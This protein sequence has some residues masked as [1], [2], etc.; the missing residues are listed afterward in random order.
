MKNISYLIVA[1]MIFFAVLTSC[2]E[3]DDNPKEFTISFETGEGG[4][5]VEPQTVREGE[6]INKPTPDP[7]RSGYTFMAW[8]KEAGVSNEWNFDT[9][10][11]TADMTLHAKWNVDN[12]NDGD[13]LCEVCGEEDCV[14]DDGAVELLEAIYYDG[15]V[16]VKYEY[17]EQNRIT[18]ITYYSYSDESVHTRTRTFIYNNTGY[19][20]SILLEY[21]SHPQDNQKTTYIYSGSKITWIKDNATHTVSLN[22]KG[23][24]E[25]QTIEY[26]AKTPTL[27]SY[28]Y[29]VRVIYTYQYTNDNVSKLNFVYGEGQSSANVST[30]NIGKT[31]YTYDNKK[32]PFYY[33]K[34]PKWIMVLDG[35]SP[36]NNVHTEVYHQ[37]DIIYSEIAINYTYDEAG[38]PTK[39]TSTSKLYYQ[40]EGYVMDAEYQYIQKNRFIGR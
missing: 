35:M 3:N 8:Y 22:S 18:K 29:F 17:D 2:S 34:T 21:P 38:F 36:L 33:C 37:Y 1:G 39:H 13:D 20:T 24:P 6:T 19:L 9:D 32:S 11:V 31:I 15:E 30:I 26:T 12:G 10:A 40:E 25:K 27:P 28:S 16:S 4:S 23:L 14:C 7:T 5:V